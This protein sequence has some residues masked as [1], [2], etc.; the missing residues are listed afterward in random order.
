MS[1]HAGGFTEMLPENWPEY[2]KDIPMPTDTALTC[3]LY[4]QEKDLKEML[5]IEKEEGMPHMVIMRQQMVVA[6]LR[7]LGKLIKNMEGRN[8]D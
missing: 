6:G 2:L 8:E 3:Y 7:L 4:D 1:D 5:E